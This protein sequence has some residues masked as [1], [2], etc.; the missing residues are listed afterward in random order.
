MSVSCECCALSSKV[1]CGGPIAHPESLPSV[2]RLSVLAKFQQRRGL[3]PL[4]QSSR[5]KK[6]SHYGDGMH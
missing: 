5:E 6:K 4:E 2:V 1:L 3:G